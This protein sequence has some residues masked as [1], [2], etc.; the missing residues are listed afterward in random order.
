MDWLHSFGTQGRCIAALVAGSL[1]GMQFASTVQPD[2]PLGQRVWTQEQLVAILEGMAFPK[3]EARDMINQTSPYLKPD[4][5][6]E[7]AVI[8]VLQT[9]G[10]G[11]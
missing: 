9:A 4:M 6:L 8:A 11:V 10:K 5:V 2:M 3:K 7:E 1:L